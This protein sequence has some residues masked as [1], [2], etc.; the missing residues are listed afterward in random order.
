VVKPKET[1]IVETRDTLCGHIKSENDRITSAEDYPNKQNA[2]SGP[3]FV[4]G[5]EK[6][7]TLVIHVDNIKIAEN[8][9]TGFEPTWLSWDVR[10]L[11]QVIPEIVTICSIRNNIIEIPC[12]GGR[13]LHVPARPLIGTIGV[14]PE[15]EGR[16]TM[17]SGQYG[18]NLDSPEICAGNTLYLPVFVNGALLHLGDVHAI[19]GDSEVNASPVEVDAECTLT[20]DL[21]K[22]KKIGWPRIVSSEYIEA[23]GA[24]KP[25]DS[26]LAIA[27]KE[28][29]LWL[30]DEYGFD[31]WDASTLLASVGMAQICGA[32]NPDLLTVSMKF[33]KKY[34]S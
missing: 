2:S 5:A 9:W 34:L 15:L 14:A 12:K 4:E 31:I 18:G 30:R 13:K 29:V 1:L 10:D 3:I 16:S 28:L 24:S 11:G 26:A 20:L 7:D 33:P 21:I 32:A 17:T 25:L 23:I 22:G 27:V 8:G 6:G 19:Q